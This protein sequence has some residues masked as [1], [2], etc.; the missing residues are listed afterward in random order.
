MDNTDLADLFLLGHDGELQHMNSVLPSGKGDAG[1]FVQVL[2]NASCKDTGCVFDAKT[3]KNS[4]GWTNNPEQYKAIFVNGIVIAM[5]DCDF[6]TLYTAQ[7][8]IK[9]CNSRNFIGLPPL[10]GDTK[11]VT[12]KRMYV[13][14]SQ[15]DENM[16]YFQS[17]EYAKRRTEKFGNDYGCLGSTATLPE[18]AYRVPTT[19]A[20]AADFMLRRLAYG[21]APYTDPRA[22]AAPITLIEEIN[23]PNGSTVVLKILCDSWFEHAFCFGT[24][25]YAI[26]QEHAMKVIET[27]RPNDLDE[28]MMR[29]LAILPKAFDITGDNGRF[30]IIADNDVTDFDRHLLTYEKVFG[31]PFGQSASLRKNS[32]SPMPESKPPMATEDS[33]ADSNSQSCMQSPLPV[34]RPFVSKTDPG[35]LKTTMSPPNM[36]A[37]TANSSGSST[38]RLALSGVPPSTQ[39]VTDKALKLLTVTARAMVHEK[40]S[41]QTDVDLLD[42]SITQLTP[43]LKSDKPFYDELKNLMT[44]VLHSSDR[45]MASFE[46]CINALGSTIA[47]TFHEQAKAGQSLVQSSHDELRL[48]VEALETIFSSTTVDKIMSMVDFQDSGS[49]GGNYESYGQ[50]FV[51]ELK[52]LVS[53]ARRFPTSTATTA[54]C[55]AVEVGNAAAAGTDMRPPLDEWNADDLTFHVNNKW[56]SHCA[57]HKV[58]KSLGT[59]FMKLYPLLKTISIQSAVK[60]GEEGN[61]EGSLSKQMLGVIYGVHGSSHQSFVIK[62]FAELPSGNKGAETKAEKSKNSQVKVKTEHSSGGRGAGNNRGHSQPHSRPGTNGPR[63]DSG[64]GTSYVTDLHSS[65]TQLSSG[66][67]LFNDYGY[68]DGPPGPH[69]RQRRGGRQDRR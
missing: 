57:E 61:S 66:F 65:A 52:A 22:F 17:E 4:P 45:R 50:M 60:M 27:Y 24:A 28:T 67:D 6:R 40:S 33:Q 35:S 51:S 10:P 43:R 31:F 14:E 25:H 2:F 19:I 48:K 59:P 46:A 8:P 16:E 5:R 38:D 21:G 29:K 9:P 49:I 23:G 58:T 37:A 53:K 47:T 30:K 36:T 54:L 1:S 20:T 15:C 69:K 39:S 44:Q 34:I 3:H 42:V 56:K 18:L 13:T 68:N 64:R 26:S 63:N 12:N 62:C 32:I 7:N 41:W 55:G 11:K